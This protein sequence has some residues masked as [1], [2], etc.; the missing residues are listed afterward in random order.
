MPLENSKLLKLLVVAPDPNDISLIRDGLAS[1]RVEIF[2]EPNAEAALQRLAAIR[3]RIVLAELA[4]PGLNGI[5]FLDRVLAQDSGTDFV[6]MSDC[7]SKESVVAAIRRGA[8]EYLPKPLRFEK[9]RVFIRGLIAEADMRY[10]T[11]RLEHGMLETYQFEGLIGRSRL[12]LEVF[13]KIRRIAPHF[14]SVLLTGPAG[15]EKELVARALHRLNPACVGPFAICNCSALVE[16]LV[17]TELFGCT[18]GAFTGATQGRQGIFEY[19]HGGTV[20]L[21]EVGELS[22]L[23]QEKLLRV[24]RNREV[25]RVGS[26]VLHKVNVRLI[27]ATHRNLRKMVADGQFTEDLFY[28]LSAVEITT[29]ALARRKEDLPLLQK[30]F[31]AKYS[32]LYGK[33]ITGIS[34]RAQVRLA[35]HSWPG[36]VRELENV[37]DSGCMLAAGDVIDLPDLPE[38]FCP[39]VV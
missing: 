20:L 34:R 37:I 25:Q 39:Y 24:L 32:S 10:Q 13:T 3:P 19:A 7:Y 26:P 14:Q 6:L 11:S 8:R 9:L 29:P 38:I 23:V 22:L 15:T 31:L 5:E 27:A 17:E 36:N 12:M 18:P 1:E 4:L 28:R 33:Q 35:L 21:D 16:S 2:T 30:H